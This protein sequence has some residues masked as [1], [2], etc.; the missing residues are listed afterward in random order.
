MFTFN[1][2]LHIKNSLR[3][4]SVIAGIQNVRPE[5]SLIEHYLLAGRLKTYVEF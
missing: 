4:Q 2:A 1:I 5:S 3:Q